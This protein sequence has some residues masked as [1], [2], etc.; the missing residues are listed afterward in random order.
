[1]LVATASL[2][3]A[4]IPASAR[5][6][7]SFSLSIGTP[8]YAYGPPPV[9][10]YPAPVYYERSRVYYAPAPVYYGPPAVYYSRPGRDYAP[11][12][13]WARHHKHWDNRR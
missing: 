4:S 9:V 8:A 6:N 10:Y 3:A 1:M 7:V 5:D 12:R 2:A 11:R 13:D